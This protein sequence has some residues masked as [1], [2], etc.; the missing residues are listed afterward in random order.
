M[1]Q[2]PVC[3]KLW[4]FSRYFS[5][6]A[7]NTSF[8]CS[9]QRDDAI[10]YSYHTHAIFMLLVDNTIQHARIV[11]VF[12]VTFALNRAC[13]LHAIMWVWAAMGWWWRISSRRKRDAFCCLISLSL[14]HNYIRHQCY[15]SIRQ[16]NPRIYRYWA[17]LIMV[18]LRHLR[19]EFI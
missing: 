4:Y 12:Y 5:R 1:C 17:I 16:P 6:P 13:L 10:N 3:K 7:N 2:R 18:E 9:S 11:L 14:L 19:S 8:I 15:I